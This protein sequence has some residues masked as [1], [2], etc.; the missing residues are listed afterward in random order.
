M[1]TL[2]DLDLGESDRDDEEVAVLLPTSSRSQRKKVNRGDGCCLML[3]SCRRRHRC[4]YCWAVVV[5]IVAGFIVGVVAAWVQ[6]HTTRESD[7]K[8]RAVNR[9]HDD[10]ARAPLDPA[11]AAGFLALFEGDTGMGASVDTDH[12]AATPTTGSGAPAGKG[13]SANDRDREQRQLHASPSTM[14]ENNAALRSRG[15]VV[16]WSVPQAHTL[17]VDHTPPYAAGFADASTY[18]TLP[19]AQDACVLTRECAGVV[20][21]HDGPPWQLR[22]GTH[23]EDLHLRSLVRSYMG[24]SASWIVP[25]FMPTSC[26]RGVSVAPAAD[27]AAAV[28]KKPPPLAL[29]GTWIRPPP[30][31]LSVTRWWRSANASSNRYA[32]ERFAIVVGNVTA[33]LPDWIELEGEVLPRSVGGHIYESAPILTWIM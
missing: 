3:G 33:G 6:P 2:A 15:C 1:L 18:E 4:C 5:G 17:F 28:V 7:W 20:T 32:R 14:T 19:E 8:P 23:G 31:P 30:P 16:H 22:H 9:Q 13:N 10:V 26:V 21:N 25:P 12:G 27:A 24:Q 11:A 29:N